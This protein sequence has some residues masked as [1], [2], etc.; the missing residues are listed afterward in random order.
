MPTPTTGCASSSMAP[1]Q[2]YRLFARG[3]INAFFG[4]MLDNMSDLVI[5]AAILMGVFKLPREIVLY[6][7][8]PG[9]A[10]GVLAGGFLYTW[11]AVR[12]A[13]RTGRIPVARRHSS[14]P[15]IGAPRKR[16]LS[17]RRSTWGEM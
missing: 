6:R 4:L 17:L 3:D 10:V 11:M 16:I 8:V 7:M 2:R 13:R 12:L 14:S 9:T 1:A 5:M 15:S